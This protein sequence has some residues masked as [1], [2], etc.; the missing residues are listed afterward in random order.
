MVYEPNSEKETHEE[1]YTEAT[2]LVERR[3]ELRHKTWSNQCMRDGRMESSY[4]K[5]FENEIYE[6][7]G[8]RKDNSSL[9]GEDTRSLDY[10]S[11][12]RMNVKDNGVVEDEGMRER[13]GVE[14]GGMS[15]A[16]MNELYTDMSYG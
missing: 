14:T 4:N 1:V 16:V 7:H 5:N 8:R 10:G 9:E 13:K 12:S 6:G 2:D 11:D 3:C 15:L